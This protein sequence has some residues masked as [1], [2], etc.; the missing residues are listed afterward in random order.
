MVV[1]DVERIFTERWMPDSTSMIKNIHP[2]PKPGATPVLY[3]ADTIRQPM[4]GMT[5]AGQIAVGGCGSRRQAR[6]Q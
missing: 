1:S 6:G 5:Y 3:L 2:W 4:G